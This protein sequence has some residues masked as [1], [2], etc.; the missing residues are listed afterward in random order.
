MSEDRR[1]GTCRWRN[2]GQCYRNPPSVLVFPVCYGERIAYEAQE[3]R[4]WVSDDTPP[5]GEW[6]DISQ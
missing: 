6:K 2:N 4:P 3:C 5:C 1:C